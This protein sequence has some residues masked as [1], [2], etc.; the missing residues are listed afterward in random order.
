MGSRRNTELFLLVAAAFPVVLLYA[1]YVVNTGAELSFTTLAVPLGL[2]A[3]FTAAHIATR[4]FAPGADP[5]IL[6]VVFLLSG[7]GITFVT[8]LAPSLAINQLMILF[9]SIVLMAVTLAL[10]KNLDMV[11][12]YKYTFGII[13]IVLLILPMFIGTEVYGSKLWI[14]I[15]G[16]GSFQPGEFAKVFLVLFLAGYLSENRELLSISNHSILG[17]KIPRLRLLMPLFVVWGICMAIV[18]FETDLGSALL[19]YTVFLMMLYVA[20]GRV[21]YVIIGMVLLLLGGFAMYQ[22]MGHVQVRFNTWLDPFADPQGGGYQLVQSLFSLADGGLV[23]V[24]IG[25]GMATMIPVVESDFIFSAIGEELGLLGGAAVLLGFMLFAVRGLT[26]AARAKSDLAAFVA[27]GLTAS[28]SFQAFLIVGGVTRLIPLTGVTLPFMSQ[29]G[30]SLLASFIIVALLMRAGDEATGRAVELAGTGTNLPV[31]DENAGATGRSKAGTRIFGASAADTVG[32]HAR[33]GSRVRRRL[34]DTPESGVL[35]RVALAKRLTR[36]VVLFTGLF[37]ILIGNITYIQ[38]IKA[39]DYQEMP[40]NNH[41]IAK[42]A[43]IQ[44]GSIIT[45]DGVTLAESLQQE[46][47]T[48][49]RSYPNG[50]LAAHTVGYFSSQYG[51]TGVE[52]SQNETLTGSQDYSSWQNA[53]NSLAGMTQPG[54]SVQLTI[55]SR[56]QAAAEQVLDGRKGAIVVLDPRTGA[57]LAKASAPTY[58][59]ADVGSLMGAD[60]D[61]D[62]PLLDRA[63]QVLYTPGS[64]FKTI[65]LAAALDAGIADLDDYYESPSS[66]EIGNADVVNIN[67]TDFGTI[68]LEMAFAYSSNVV[69]GQLANEI[70]AERLVQYARAFGYGQSLG[71]DFSTAES[72]MADPAQMTEWELAWAGAGQPVGQGHTAGPQTTVM[73]N[74][75]MVAAI[76]NNGLAMQPYVVS[77]ILSPTGTVVSTTQARSLGQAVSAA[78]ADKVKESMLAVVEEG[79][80]SYASVYGVQVAGKTG[81]AEVSDSQTNT[82]F[83][84]FA[85]YDTPT[86]AISVMIED[87]DGEEST[88]AAA[89]AGEVLAVALAAQGA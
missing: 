49:A 72:V 1:M 53:I 22:I 3:A 76:A 15:P 37:A 71:Q 61:E 66:M 74:A 19:F 38:V 75:V 52:A 32:S 33:P 48:Y 55:N 87:W 25:R 50:N 21:S 35:G 59:N 63:T 26:V 68:S 80:G 56:I 8:R 18:A 4:I 29:G 43:Y 12:R 86:V 89:A 20:T 51:A 64:T 17:L 58:D 39:K 88:S 30:S 5:A 42:A 77:Q 73:Q 54:N 27:S 84:G 24:G 47:G 82:A 34:L 13:G 40:N 28:I 69:F 67:E 85:P 16:V 83:V 6:P 14:E 65:T 10:V 46:D 31:L 44:R 60:D 23:G 81:S 62:A 2:F 9:A 79:S 57:V 45:S 78:T 41:T 36:E 70:G 7:I 11:R